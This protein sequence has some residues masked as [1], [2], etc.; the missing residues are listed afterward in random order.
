[1]VA[2]SL[3]FI[4]KGLIAEDGEHCVERSFRKVEMPARIP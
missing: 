1:V 3:V 2:V 4:R